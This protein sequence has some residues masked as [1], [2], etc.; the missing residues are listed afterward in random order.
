MTLYV[1][2]S[3]A[4]RIGAS[5]QNF[6]Q[7]KPNQFRF[8][9]SCEDSKFGKVKARAYI[10][11]KNDGLNVSCHH[12]GLSQSL[13]SFINHENAELFLEYKLEKF[14]AK[15]ITTFHKEDESDRPKV[16]QQITANN[17]NDII[18]CDS[19]PDSHPVKQFVKKR[20]IPDYY[21]SRLGFVTDFNAF[22]SKYN[23]VFKEKHKRYPRLIIPFYNTDDA[24]V[25][26]SCR[27]FGPESPKYIKLKLNEDDTLIYGLWKVDT[28]R[29]IFATEGQFD[30]MFLDNSIAVG[31]AD[32]DSEFLRKHKDKIIVVPDSDYKR[33]RHVYGQLE[34]IIDA[35]F[36]VALLPESIQH[37]D[38]NECIVDGNF[39]PESLTKILSE[40]V[41]SGAA[42]KVELIFR[43]RFTDAK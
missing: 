8:S 40:N 23:P 31:G 32:Y 41:F 21:Y 1:D 19:L 10:Y 11:Q 17:D 29:D 2:I 7:L 24:I 13:W 14:K 20:K 18:F 4:R 35:G 30:S 27:A 34:K 12:C 37:K 42:A 38:I 39:T 6:K 43:R 26:F 9:H 36:R 5:L 3:F 28:S 22:A 15:A 25:G 16:I 33:N